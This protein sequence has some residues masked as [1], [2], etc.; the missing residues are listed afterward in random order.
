M[1][2][3]PRIGEGPVPADGGRRDRGFRWPVFIVAMLL[4]N[5][6]VCVVTV[7][8]ALSHP[9][10]IEPDYYNKAL[11][12]D[13]LRGLEAL[14]V[15]AQLRAAPTADGKGFGLT[16]RT[17][18]GRALTPIA[19]I[20]V[21]AHEATPGVG[22]PLGIRGD[23]AGGF[24]TTIPLTRPGLW[25]INATITLDPELEPVTLSTEVTVAP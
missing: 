1:N 24:E 25:R 17:S 23:G 4:L 5:V 2:A 12:W 11:R 8:A 10:T 15:G 7:V 22:V 3:T 14:A 18:E 13:E 6:G 21:A 19:V 9:V 16:V 20:A